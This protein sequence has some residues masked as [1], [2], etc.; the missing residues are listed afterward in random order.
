MV[1][2][3]NA[4]LGMVHSAQIRARSVPLVPALWCSVSFALAQTPHNVQGGQERIRPED[5]RSATQTDSEDKANGKAIVAGESESP[6]LWK[7]AGSGEGWQLAR[8]SKARQAR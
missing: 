6:Q 8:L 1:A 4:R 5:S 7:M 2:H 3:A